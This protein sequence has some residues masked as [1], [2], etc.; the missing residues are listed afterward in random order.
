MGRSRNYW[1]ESEREVGKLTAGL[2]VSPIEVEEEMRVESGPL[3]ASAEGPEEPVEVQRP[4]VA[5]N[6]ATPTAQELEEHQATAHAVHRAWCGHCMR[7]R[8]T[9]ARHQTVSHDEESEV[10]VIASDYYYFGEKEGETA[11]LEVKDCRSK[12]TWSTAVPAKGPDPFVVNFLLACINE[13]GY[14]RLILKS[15]N[16]PAIIALKR[17]TKAQTKDCEI[18]LQEAPTGDHSA[19]GAIEVAVRDQKRQVRALLSELEEH[20]GKIEDTHPILTWLSRHAAFCLSRFAIKDDGKTPHQHLTGRKWNR[21]MVTFGEKIYFRPLD[22]YKVDDQESGERRKGDLGRRVMSGYYVGTHGRNA[23]V[24]VMTTQGVIKGNTVHRKPE[25]ER[26]DRSELK[27]LKGVP[28]KLRPREAGDLEHR[29]HI[30][31]P[32]A[33]EKLTPTVRDGGPRQL[34]VRKKDLEKEDGTYDYTPGCKGCEAL[35]VGLPSVTH[36]MTCRNRLQERLKET[37]EG[38]K[39]LADVER[40]QEEG[41]EKKAKTEVTGLPDPTEQEVRSSV[42]LG[43]PEEEIVTSPKRGKESVERGEPGKKAKARPTQGEKRQGEAI[44]DLY[45]D[46]QENAGPLVVST[47]GS[48]ETQVEPSAASAGGAASGSAAPGSNLSHDQFWSPAVP[49]SAQPEIRRQDPEQDIQSLFHIGVESPLEE[50]TKVE[51]SALGAHDVTELFSPPRFTE[52][53]KA[54]GLLPGYA[55]DLETGWDLTDKT[56]VKCLDKILEEEDP[57]LTTGSPP[58]DPFLILQ[59][60]NKGRMDPEEFQKRLDK[61]KDML[62]TSCELYKKRIEKGRYFLHEHPKTAKSW[63]ENCVKEISEMENVEIVEGPM[64][65]WKMI[66]RDASGEGYIRRPTCWMTNSPELAKTLRGICTNDLQGSKREWHRHIHLVNGRAKMARVYPP[67]LV[68]AILQALKRQMALDGEYREVNAMEAGPSPDEDLHLEDYVEDFVPKKSDE[69]QD[70]EDEQMFFDDITGVKLDTQGVLAARRE[71]LQWLHRAQ[72]YEKRTIQECWER[73]GKNPITLKWIDRNKGDKERPNYR[74]RIVVREVKKQHGALPGHMLF[75]NMPPLEAVKILCSELATRKTSKKGRDLRMALYDISRAHFYGEAQREIYVTLPPGDEQE[76][77]C[78]IL[79]KTM[80]GTQDASHVWQQ[81][82]SNHLIKNSFK[83]GQAWTSVFRHD[84]LDIKLLVHGDDFLVLADK[85]GQE[86]MQKILK[87]KYEYR[88]DG[89]IGR[90]SGDHL[91]ILN[92]IVTFEKETGKVTYEADPRHAEMII[93]QL[94]LQN[95]KSV[96]T[97][98]EKKKASDVLAS[99]GLPPVTAEQTTLYRSLVMRAQFLAQDRADLSETVKSLTRKMK[100]PNESDM[101]DL[102][103]LGRYLVG[104]PRVVNVYHPQKSTN[105]IK[106]YADSDHAGCLLT[107]RSTT[108][109]TISIG[110]HCVKHGSNLQSTIA[111]SS[112]ESEFYALTRGVALGLSLRSLMQ[113]WGQHYDL[114]IYSDSSAARGTS[115]RRGLGKLRHVQTRY[116]WIQERVAN[117]DLAVKCVSTKTNTADLCTK[118]VNKE[119]SERHMK[120][121][122]QE[123]REGKATGAKTLESTKV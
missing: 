69:G 4:R 120:T 9:A 80:Y 108:G 101:K 84:E 19:N 43:Q 24:L 26:W 110:R 99:V 102:K 11:N 5:R 85:E 70:Q 2:A 37:E 45:H 94:N 58:C 63:K 104:R 54:F 113:D 21:P 65:R 118:P 115:A 67:V 53:C 82:Y 55:V 114:E 18:V 41:K 68:R 16:E 75:S 44:D 93:R 111:L 74:S 97:P 57:Y 107:R 12:M 27:D 64:C 89:E 116:L 29:M 106:V 13:T 1:K 50:E 87:E 60:L 6:V 49:T 73:T 30:T 62:K 86:Y 33:T 121:L 15:D 56:Q 35:M 100:A 34:Y 17:E 39:R 95:A 117:H 8:A 98:S 36:N 14:R 90:N 59:G 23:D 42:A 103:R 10:P 61:G 109:Y 31:L 122:C 38:R 83:Q 3:A 112:G 40:R 32:E 25:S 46:G 91:T 47:R 28:W 48:A 105:V 119:T 22:A 81:D 20:Y 79:K 72:V 92:R 96:A 51:L 123:F 77:F 88:C 76:G 78:A 7:A 52:E 66:G 71:E